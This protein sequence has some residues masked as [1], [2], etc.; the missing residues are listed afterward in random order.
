MSCPGT[1]QHV[2]YILG[3]VRIVVCDIRTIT[4]IVS[5]SVPVDVFFNETFPA[6]CVE[7]LLES[8]VTQRIQS[9]NCTTEESQIRNLR[10]LF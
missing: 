5:R 4:D 8:Y 2:N 3:T 10:T 7:S 6:I 9:L 1:R